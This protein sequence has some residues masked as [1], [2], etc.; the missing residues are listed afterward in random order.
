MFNTGQVEISNLRIFDPDNITELSAPKL[1]GKQP[2]QDDTMSVFYNQDTDTI[3]IE[4]SGSVFEFHSND[5]T[6][7]ISLL[8]EALTIRGNV[9]T[10]GKPKPSA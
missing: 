10:T 7:V 2:S 1:N 8:T 6:T 5:V 9:T 4:Q 3:S